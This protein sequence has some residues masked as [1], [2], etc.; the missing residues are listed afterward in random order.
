MV[1]FEFRTTLLSPT[2]TLPLVAKASRA[3]V[4]RFIPLDEFGR[5]FGGYVMWRQ[6]AVATGEMPGEGLGVW[7]SR[8]VA[9]F[10]RVLR[11]RGAE[12]VRVE[13]PGP[14]QALKVVSQDH[15]D[16]SRGDGPAA[17]DDAP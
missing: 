11:E 16:Y 17:A 5:L 12:I 10:R 2:R 6:P 15:R 1:I 13:G 9:R 8:N 7:G 4:E 14:A 3:E